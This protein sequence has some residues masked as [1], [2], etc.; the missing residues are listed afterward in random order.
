MA[1]SV[2]WLIGRFN[3]LV[4]ISLAALVYLICLYLFKAVTKADL[5]DLL[6]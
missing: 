6:S 5:R 2:Y 1:L 4:I 3:L